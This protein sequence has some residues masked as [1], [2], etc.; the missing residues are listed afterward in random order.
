[1]LTKATY[2]CDGCGKTQEVTAMPNG[3]TVAP[4]GQRVSRD[5][6]LVHACSPCCQAQVDEKDRPTW[7]Q[8]ATF[9]DP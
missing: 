2:K 8:D 9:G 1:M 4:F 7:Q 3:V 6:R 5:G